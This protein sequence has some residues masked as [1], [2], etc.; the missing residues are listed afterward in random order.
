MDLFLTGMSTSPTSL[1]IAILETA[2]AIIKIATI[3]A[4][5][6][7]LVRHF[8]GTHVATV[9]HPTFSSITRFHWV[10]MLLKGTCLAVFTQFKLHYIVPCPATNSF[11]DCCVP[12]QPCAWPLPI[13]GS[14]YLSAKSVFWSYKFS[15]SIY[16]GVMVRQVKN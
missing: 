4:S 1:S 9:T 16:W 11:Q 15:S 2:I 8:R 12:F 7:F 6:P 3:C 5:V 14:Q 13:S 10:G